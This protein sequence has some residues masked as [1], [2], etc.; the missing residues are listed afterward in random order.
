MLIFVF[1]AEIE[2]R[3]K[4]NQ[5]SAKGGKKKE[6][7][8]ENVSHF[9]FQNVIRGVKEITMMGMGLGPHTYQV[10]SLTFLILFFTEFDDTSVYL[11]V[12]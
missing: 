1:G 2:R 9:L 4:N 10:L 6:G 8:F 11:L 3:E 7:F 12:I 5:F